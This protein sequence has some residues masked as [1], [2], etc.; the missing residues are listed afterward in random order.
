MCWYGLSVVIVLRK[1]QA[2]KTPHTVEHGQSFFYES[3]LTKLTLPTRVND[4]SSTLIDHLIT[5][6]HKNSIFPG[7][8]KTDLTDHY[9]T[10]YFALLIHLP[11]PTN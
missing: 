7:I 8:I 2:T 11:S 6:D 10:V 1:L 3:K 9:P 4:V 5:N